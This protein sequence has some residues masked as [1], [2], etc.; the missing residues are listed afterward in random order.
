MP[1][2]SAI[3]KGGLKSTAAAVK[4]LPPALPLELPLALVVLGNGATLDVGMLRGVV[5]ELNPT[6][7]VVR[8]VD[9]EEVVVEVNGS[10]TLENVGA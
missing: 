3:H 7:P 10:K 8:P 1:I 4:A 2:P 9:V 6:G 5:V